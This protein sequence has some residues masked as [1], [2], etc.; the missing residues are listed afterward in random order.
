M[1]PTYAP[2]SRTRSIDPRA[3]KVSHPQPVGDLFTFKE[4]EIPSRL[5]GSPNGFS[6]SARFTKG[7]HKREASELFATQPI[8]VSRGELSRP[9][10]IK[11]SPPKQP[12]SQEY[13]Q[14]QGGFPGS[15]MLPITPD[16][17]AFPVQSVH[18]SVLQPHSFA[19][20]SIDDNV[21][22][23]V[24][25]YTPPRTGRTNSTDSLA[26]SNDERTYGPTVHCPAPW[27]QQ[28][29]GFPP[30]LGVSQ[31][32]QQTMS[33]PV[34]SGMRSHSLSGWD[35]PTVSDFQAVPATANPAGLSARPMAPLPSPRK[36]V[37]SEKQP[38]TPKSRK[39]SG[40]KAKA[41]GGFACS[42]IN[43]T[44]DDAEK[45]LTGVAPSGSAKRRRDVSGSSD[46]GDESPK[47]AKA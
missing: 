21:V 41:A 1:N 36:R 30:S 25:Y 15:T 6:K 12:Y 11:V 22:L 24:T 2:F 10:S 39:A 27:Q 42:F 14:P 26:S 9:L 43:F 23:P 13:Y 47:R 20:G 4:R 5:D 44:Q 38:A 34:P 33:L 18:P 17:Q 40:K 7:S 8:D 28:L 35:M 46:D 45:L 3:R 29:G 31:P 19:Y 16:E 37:A 32:M